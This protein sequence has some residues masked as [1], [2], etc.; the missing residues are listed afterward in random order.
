MFQGRSNVAIDPEKGRMTFPVKHRAAFVTPE[1]SHLTITRHPQGCLLIF[2]RAAWLEK[3]QALLKLPMSA[4]GWKRMFV[5]NA[6]DIELDSSGRI[7]IPSE[8]R[9]P[10]NLEKDAVLMGMGDHLELWD[11]STLARNESEVAA[12]DVPEAIADF[13]F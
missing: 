1:G 5:G 7:L 8:L 4:I 11:E 12:G 3:K 13:I 9:R 2:P 6:T 10:V